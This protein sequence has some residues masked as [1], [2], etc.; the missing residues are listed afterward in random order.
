MK[1]ERQHL[2]PRVQ[3]HKE[4]RREEL[5]KHL[6]LFQVFLL[7]TSYH[8]NSYII[9]LRLRLNIP[10]LQHI[11]CHMH[12]YIHLIRSLL[13]LIP[14]DEYGRDGNSRGEDR[15]HDGRGWGQS[16]GG[17]GQGEQ[18]DRLEEHAEEQQK[19]GEADAKKGGPEI[20]ATGLS[21][22]CVHGG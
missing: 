21:R 7:L 3:G 22:N 13:R 20:S 14:Q 9:F 5:W 1:Q 8:T 12:V 6:A 11:R 15:C 19:E 16:G 17:G 2:R 18:E 10:C 4:G